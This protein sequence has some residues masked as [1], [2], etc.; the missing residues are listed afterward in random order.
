MTKAKAPSIFAGLKKVRKASEQETRTEMTESQV[1]ALKIKLRAANKINVFPN[2]FDLAK[3]FR[4]S[5]NFDNVWHNFGEYTNVD[6]AAAVGSIVSVAFFGEKAM[7]G[8]FD[9]EV[10]ENH[11]E[12]KAWIADPENA[13]VLARY[14]SG[15]SVLSTKEQSVSTS[16]PEDE[17][18]FDDDI[19]F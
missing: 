7:Q 16:E 11:T 5:L 4:V 1:N 17:E 3:P 6:A 10:A 2:K 14:T 15:T 18:G 8:D 13:E 12:F 19:P 9:H